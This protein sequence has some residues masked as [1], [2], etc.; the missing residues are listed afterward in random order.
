MET[1]GAQTHW[2]AGDAMV[3]TVRSRVGWKR[4]FELILSI[5]LLTG[6]GYGSKGRQTENKRHETMKARN[7]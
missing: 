5:F 1:E 7:M 6:Q 3:I 2:R 4:T